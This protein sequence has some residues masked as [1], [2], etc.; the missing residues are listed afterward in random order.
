MSTD[1]GHGTQEVDYRGNVPLWRQLSF[2][3]RRRVKKVAFY[4]SLFG[5]LAVII[6]PLFW[7]FSTAFRPQSQMFTRPV[8]LLPESVTL[9]HFQTI[10]TDSMFLTFYANSIIVALGVVLLTTVTS[11]LGGYG[12]TRLDIPL[13]K[14]FARTILFG[15]MF[16]PILLAI[17]M[18]IF[19]QRLG[20]IDTY[21]GLILAETAISLPFSLW[22]MWKFFQT[23]P[24]SLEESAITAGAT[25]F[26]AF[27]D[28]ALPM[29]KPGMIAVAVFSYAV[30]W[31]SFTMP[32]VLMISES[33]WPLTIGV[34]S[35]T[36]QQH[37]YWGQVM[38]ASALI[39]LPA[40]VFVF[41]LQKY[42]LRGFR[43]GGIG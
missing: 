22:L 25:R 27:Y 31:N 29:A 10:L 3:Q 40:F 41:F 30:S 33:K 21:V 24:V 5:G 12:L 26:Q 8:P 17:P 11:T 43:A 39:I 36:Q 9:T 32:K 37:V 42:L 28:V 34:Y 6:F 14:T 18:F 1:T 20:V 23:V 2:D 13:K 38:A 4:I 15:Y 35:F 19:W 16:P 7:M